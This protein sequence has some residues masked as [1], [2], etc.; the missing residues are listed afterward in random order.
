M[1]FLLFLVITVIIYINTFKENFT[2]EHLN[3]LAPVL[4]VVAGITVLLVVLGSI[5]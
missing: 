1:Y 2:Q 3:K 5:S 4:F